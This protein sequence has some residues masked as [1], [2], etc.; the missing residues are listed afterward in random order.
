MLHICKEL[1]LP[2]TGKLEL[3]KITRLENVGNKPSQ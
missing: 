1:K 2:Q 3:H